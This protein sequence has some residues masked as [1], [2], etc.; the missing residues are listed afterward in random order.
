MAER[1]VDMRHADLGAAEARTLLRGWLDSID[2]SQNPWTLIEMMQEDDFSHADLA[3]RARRIHERRL[4]GAVE[5]VAAAAE[6]RE[7]YG[8]AAKAL[9]EACIP[10][11]P[12]V[13][14]A[15]ILGKE[16]ANLAIREGEPGRVALV[17][18]GAG[19]MHGVTHTI[20]RIREH[21]VPGWDV[22]V[23]GTD[24][25]V[26]RRLPAVAEIEIPFYAGM[27]I[28][29]PSVPE[30]VQ[31]LVDGRYDMIHL[32][33][34]GPAGIGAAITARIGGTPLLGSYHTELAAYAGLRT[35]DPTLEAGMRMALALFYRQCE[36]VLSPSASADESLVGLGI[37]P[38]RIGR[39]GRGV[40][41]DLYDPAKRDAGAYPGEITVLY[42]GR[43]TKEKGAELLAES[44][45]RAHE[46][47]PRLHLLLA[48]GGPEEEMLRDRLGEHATF[49]GW[50]DRE[51]LARAYASADVFLF[52]SQTDTYGQVIVEAQASGLPVVAVAEGG[53]VSLITDRRTGWLCDPDADEIAGAVA[54]LA[55]SPF[56]RERIARS[57]L[58]E[59]QGRT[60]DAARSQLAAGYDRALGGG[61][62]RKPGAIPALAEVA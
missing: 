24:A 13:P 7:G 20:E 15:T 46:R 56:L 34:P 8:D 17:V 11:V 16:M 9:F 36:V 30:L 43:L 52:C 32:A 1:A 38:E 33:S 41:L 42:A 3:R 25:H 59:I 27:S 14:S 18:D 54:Q 4:R 19:S 55:A 47:D 44:F 12:Y 62:R 23:V 37:D 21:G 45:L 28:G 60:W 22:E 10:A 2:L 6:A 48:G 29:V 50:L 39:W 58:A 49:L 53:P 61:T 26:D 35:E 57:A 31:T 5:G 40:D 51:Q